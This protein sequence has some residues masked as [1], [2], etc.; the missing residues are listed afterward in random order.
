MKNVQNEYEK[1]SLK[2][3]WR[4]KTCM[5]TVRK[6][7]CVLRFKRIHRISIHLEKMCAYSR[8]AHLS[9]FAQ[10]FPGVS[11]ESLRF[12][13]SPVDPGELGELVVVAQGYLSEHSL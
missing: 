10:D 11:I 4:T 13:G 2:H 6:T 12:S 5:W 1:I 8:V 3:T 7:Y 9:G